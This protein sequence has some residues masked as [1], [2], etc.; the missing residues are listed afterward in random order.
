MN[1]L[2]TR[3]HTTMRTCMTST[4]NMPTA[5]TIRLLPIHYRTA[6]GTS[7]PDLFTRTRTIPIFTI[8]TT[9]SSIRPCRVRSRAEERV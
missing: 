8:G 2:T 5:L 3:P 7:I 4:I 1:T 6:T 9:I